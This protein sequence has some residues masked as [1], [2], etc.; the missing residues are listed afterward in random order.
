MNGKLDTLKKKEILNTTNILIIAFLFLFTMFSLFSRDFFTVFNFLSMIKNA[1][2]VGIL[3]AGMTLVLISGEVDLS[4]G[5]NIG[6]TS[7]IFAYAYSHEVGLY[8]SIL[9]GLAIGIFTGLL[10][11]LLVVY[12]RMNAII[13]TLGTLAVTQGLAFTISNGLGIVVMDQAF[14]KLAYGKIGFIPLPTIITFGLM[15]LYGWILRF[16]KFGRSM[17]AIGANRIVAYL[18][19]LPLQRVKFICLFL[20]GLMA[21]FVG[22]LMTSNAASGMPQLGRGIELEVLSIVILGG[23]SLDGGEGS[24]LGTLFALLI[25]TVVYNG[26]TVGNVPVEVVNIIKGL[27]LLTV[28][29]FYE[30]RK[31]RRA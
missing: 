30:V 17:K 26:L 3:A 7:V 23:A 11:C 12:F 25:L 1:S 13:T 31:A 2:F 28:V 8:Y 18:C 29:G 14:L 22:L 10:N 6:L 19:G 24:M 15:A 21:S 4:I 5:G 20:N 9:L 16:S 27:V